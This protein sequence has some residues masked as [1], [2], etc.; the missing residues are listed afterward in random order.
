MKLF[1]IKMH[2]KEKNIGYEWNEETSQIFKD[3]YARQKRK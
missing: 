3:I 1:F 2:I